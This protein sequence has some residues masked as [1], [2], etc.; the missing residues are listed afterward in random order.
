MEEKRVKGTDDENDKTSEAKDEE[1]D[2]DD[3][4]E[5]DGG[6]VD[7]DASDSSPSASDPF[8]RAFNSFS[9]DST[10]VSRHYRLSDPSAVT[11]LLTSH[12]LEW[13]R[14]GD[15][16]DVRDC[17]FC[18]PTRGL[19]DNQWKLGIWLT[20]GSFH[21]FRCGSK[22]SWFDLH[23]RL[24]GAP[25]IT[26]AEIN[27]V[28]AQHRYKGSEPQSHPKQYH[29]PMMNRATATANVPT[30]ASSSSSRSASPPL[31]KQSVVEEYVRNLFT[32]P[33]FA[34]VLQY[35]TETRGLTHQTLLHYQIGACTHK[36]LRKDK[37]KEKGKDE[38]ATQTSTK[39]KKEQAAKGQGKD[40]A[41]VS[42]AAVWEEQLCITMPWVKT[43]QQREEINRH[44]MSDK[45]RKNKLIAKRQAMKRAERERAAMEE[46]Q[47]RTQSDVE[48]GE[49]DVE[50][51]EDEEDEDEAEDENEDEEDTT[52]D[53]PSVTDN[54]TASS[55]TDPQQARE[56]AS[57]DSSD[58]T[59]QATL[60]L[61]SATPDASS[62]SAS[63]SSSSS[64]FVSPILPGQLTE[65]VKLRSLVSK[66]NQ[67]LL[68]AGGVW[69]FFGWH[70][71]PPDATELVIT[72]GEFD[73][74]ACWQATGM[75]TVSLPNGARSLP[76]D[77]LPLLERFERLY[78]WFDEDTAGA[79]GMQKIATKLG[80][81]RCL[82]VHTNLASTPHTETEEAEWD[83]P[84]LPFPSSIDDIPLPSAT[85]ALT[86]AS[87]PSASAS[88]YPLLKDANDALRAGVDLISLIAAAEPLS[89]DNI[90]RFRDLR[91]Q[92]LRD[93]M[94]PSALR[95]VPS[96]FFPTFNKLL[97]GHRPGEL[98]IVTGATGVGKT[99]VL[100]QLSL[101]FCSQGV[102]TLWGS[103]EIRNTKLAKVMLQQYANSN[104]ADLQAEASQVKSRHKHRKEPN[105]P[106]SSDDPASSP[107]SSDA[108]PAASA[109]SAWH[110]VNGWCDKFEQLPLYF[111]TFFGST[112]LEH[113][114]ETMN[115]AVY[116]L[117]VEHILLD[118][119][120][121]MLSDQGSGLDRFELQD[122]AIS[123]F[124][125][126]ASTNNVHITL[127][128]HPRKES[129]GMGRGAG[130][131]VHSVFGSG[132]ATQE[133]DN[134]LVIQ[135]PSSDVGASGSNS[136]SPSYRD[137]E[138][139]V[140]ELED[141][142]LRVKAGLPEEF[143]IKQFRRIEIL[144]N[145]FDGQ[146]GNIPFV[147]HPD[148][149]RIQEVNA[150]KKAA[151]AAHAD[152]NA[153]P[154]RKRSGSNIV[155]KGGRKKGSSTSA[156]SSAPLWYRPP[157]QDLSFVIAA[158]A[159]T[160]SNTTNEDH[161]QPDAPHTSAQPST[162]ATSPH[163]TTGTG[164]SSSPSAADSTS[165]LP[166]PTSDLPNTAVDPHPTAAASASA[167]DPGSDSLPA[168]TPK[169]KR[170]RT[171]KTTTRSRKQEQATQEHDVD[172]NP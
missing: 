45:E 136:G 2:D 94:F 3:D 29:R 127:V 58:P 8:N 86:S 34:P 99:T 31:P 113:V 96:R 114:L 140:E 25:T 47:E 76:V 124:R 42:D 160:G 46:I 110:D 138:S 17:P 121:F 103:F 49:E 118:N 60:A 146:L 83:A 57:N 85:P 4:A 129:S 20:N 13:R 63:S 109:A 120:Q 19:A 53:A 66:G 30:S 163:S 157:D 98:T 16:V 147:Y 88:P 100:S 168:Q 80:K 28:A 62:T 134:V 1:E 125:S 59:A 102:R 41:A 27:T 131:N 108:D 104:F 155:R 81:H 115:H 149:C 117:D 70:T 122:R 77:V 143:D 105:D 65:R 165:P 144:K 23:K 92:V 106:N 153:N 90:V 6:D 24:T 156:A 54:A 64:S 141:R 69:S 75:P 158:N 139:R 97:K 12:G 112:P 40:A 164:T 36:F 116:A 7:V 93:V 132:K 43:K 172:A 35:L 152:S 145:R 148:T 11:S 133:A 22:G 119:L 170:K 162:P 154:T 72:E 130:L 169:A 123:E 73:A 151:A 68:P 5:D 161:P 10:F 9:P 32:L 14:Q 87:A 128:I 52:A 67:R 111:L 166:S 37:D 142:L 50:N 167:S 89:H 71:V 56:I 18:H 51:E 79:E 126:F 135:A 44:M 137:L 55:H 82:A 101:D 39:G 159:D 33:K 48:E 21:C 38:D 171:T 61:A 107:P 15:R 74:M 78:L 26:T 150:E 95:G 84:E 91:A